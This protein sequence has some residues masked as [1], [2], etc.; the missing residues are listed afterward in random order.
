M[1]KVYRSLGYFV[2]GDRVKVLTSS[3]TDELNYYHSFNRGD[4][5]DVIGGVMHWNGHIHIIPV[6][7]VIDG[8]CQS[9]AVKDLELVESV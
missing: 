9:V 1:G 7:R 5:C 2:P 3:H 4:I 8:R 6:S